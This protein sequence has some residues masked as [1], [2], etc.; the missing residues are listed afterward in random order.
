L[1]AFIAAARNSN[2]SIHPFAG[3]AGM[4]IIDPIAKINARQIAVNVFIKMTLNEGWYGAGYL[5]QPV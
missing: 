2:G 4:V 5:N 1:A 3:V